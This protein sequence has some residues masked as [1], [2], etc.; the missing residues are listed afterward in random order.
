VTDALWHDEPTLAKPGYLQSYVDP[1]FHVKVTRIG[2]DP[3]ATIPVVAGRWGELARHRYSK[4]QPWNADQSLILLDKVSG[5]SGYLFL[6]GA[7]YEPVFRRSPAGN[8]TR[9]H[10]RLAGV[11]VYLKKGSCEVGHWDVR[12]N[13]AAPIMR[14]AGYVDCQIGPYEGNLSRDGSWIGVNGKRTA[15]GHAVG[16][17]VDLANRRKYP[18]IDLAARGISYLGWISVSPGARYLVVEGTI[19]GHAD[20]TQLFDLQGAPV[21]SP[22][23]EYGRPS[24]YDL[25]V[26][27]NGDEVAV[28]VS[29]SAP[30][31]GRVIMRRLRDG[32]VTALTPGGYASH[33][34]TRNA[35]RPGWAYVSHTTSDAKYA[36]FN[37]E[38]FAVKLD[39]SMRIERLAQLHTSR[40]DYD[41][42]AQAVPSPDGRRVMFASNWKSGTGRPV[43]AYVVDTRPLC[44]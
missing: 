30:D 19:D 13:S 40:V 26:D 11:M 3:D 2:G 4:D 36:P 1:V 28:G 20:A 12:A 35:G 15:D 34:S 6:D 8:E 42:E 32:L 5:V 25:S 27:A 24:H 38:V 23:S 41:S 21:G 7:T 31:N 10:P 33:T 39:G 17:A 22:W 16:F 29:K 9:W 18:D 14:L 43:Q 37:D 44:R